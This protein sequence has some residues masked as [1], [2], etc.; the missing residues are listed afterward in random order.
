MASALAFNS[1]EFAWSDVT[2]QVGSRVL[3]GIQAVSYKV[4]QEKGFVYGKGNKP[5]AIQ[6][7]NFAYEGTIKVLQSE[8]PR[9]QI[10]P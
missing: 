2:V 5:L 1:E 3:T 10:T 6:K 8:L 7:G 4:S 9:V